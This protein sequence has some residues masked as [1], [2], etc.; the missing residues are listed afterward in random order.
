MLLVAL[1]R[2][3]VSPTNSRNAETNFKFM[4]QFDFV[5]LLACAQSLKSISDR[6]SLCSTSDRES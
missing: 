5:S 4:L 3:R 1:H 6:E 2:C